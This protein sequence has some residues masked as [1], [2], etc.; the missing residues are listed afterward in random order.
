MESRLYLISNKRACQV[1]LLGIEVAGMSRSHEECHAF[2]VP[3]LFQEVVT[4]YS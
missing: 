3:V 2:S 4:E 1:S